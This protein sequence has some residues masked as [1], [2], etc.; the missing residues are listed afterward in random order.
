MRKQPTKFLQRDAVHGADS[1]RIHRAA[2]GERASSVQRRPAEVRGSHP[3]EAEATPFPNKLQYQLGIHLPLLRELKASPRR[4]LEKRAEAN[5]DETRSDARRGI[6]GMLVPSEGASPNGCLW[7]EAQHFRAF[8]LPVAM[9]DMLFV[10]RLAGVHR[11]RQRARWR[12]EQAPRPQRRE[13]PHGQAESFFAG[14][15]LPTLY[16]QC[17]RGFRLLSTA[18]QHRTDGPAPSPER[19][20]NG[21][22]L[23]DRTPGSSSYTL[24]FPVILGPSAAPGL[25]AGPGASAGRCSAASTKVQSAREYR[26]RSSRWVWRFPR[27]GARYVCATTPRPGPEQAGAATADLTRFARYPV[28]EANARGLP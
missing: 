25:F 20:A 8:Q 12:R 23:V 16:L 14:C 24:H 21:C 5:L 9:I 4:H 1:Q 15:E 19:S 18:D 2:P 7:L 28:F 13:P 11:A 17:R 22:R 6:G 10:N 27:Q 26:E 3:D